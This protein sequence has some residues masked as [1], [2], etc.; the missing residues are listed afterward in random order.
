MGEYANGLEVKGDI[1]EKK[2]WIIRIT[3]RAACSKALKE[4]M[5][6]PYTIFAIG[7][8]DGKQRKDVVSKGKIVVLPGPYE[9]AVS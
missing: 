7:N 4:K 6:V 3:V 9:G 8:V 2:D 5:E 1:D